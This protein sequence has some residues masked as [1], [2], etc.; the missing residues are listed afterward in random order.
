M[1]QLDYNYKDLKLIDIR[2]R[3][4]EQKGY[5]ILAFESLPPVNIDKSIFENVLFKIYGPMF[6]KDL[7]LNDLLKTKW[8]AYI[9]EG[10]HMQWDSDSYTYIKH[11]GAPGRNYISRIDKAGVLSELTYAG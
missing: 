5:Y 3:G 6:L 8:N 7:T 11:D 1:K 9:S 10:Y 4:S 2:Y